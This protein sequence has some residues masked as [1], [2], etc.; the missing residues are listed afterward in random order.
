MSNIIVNKTPHTI[1]IVDAD[2]K[3]IVSIPPTAPAA[4]CAASLTPNGSLG[5]IPLVKQEFGEVQDLPPAQA[6]QYFIVSGLVKAACPD[7]VDLLAVA[8]LVRDQQGRVVGCK[9][10]TL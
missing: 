1:N 10:L 4:R 2:G 3:E 6:G 7:R 8:D 5:N 9:S